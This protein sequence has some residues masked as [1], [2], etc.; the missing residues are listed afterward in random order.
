VSA[1]S[2]IPIFKD[3]LNRMHRWQCRSIIFCYAL[4]HVEPE[5]SGPD[6]ARGP[7]MCLLPN[8]G[9]AKNPPQCRDMPWHKLIL[10]AV[11]EAYR[12]YRRHDAIAPGGDP[13]CA[14]LP[15]VSYEPGSGFLFEQHLKVLSRLCE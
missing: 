15:N 1:P 8:I 11:Q 6:D 2:N 3:R 9:A 12:T 5:M 4:W 10:A 13:R 14:S 7:D